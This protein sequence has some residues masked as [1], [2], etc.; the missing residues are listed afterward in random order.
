MPPKSPSA[1]DLNHLRG[2]TLNKGDAVAPPLVTAS[3][4][5][6]P[7]DPDGSASYGRSDNATWQTTE[8]LLSYLEQAPALLFPSG[9]AAI[10]APLFA[11]LRNGDRV[12]IPSDGY[13][14]TRLLADQFLARLGVEVD[15]RP[16]RSFAS[17][18]FDGYAMIFVETPSNPDLDLCDLSQIAEAAR[19]AGA[20]SVADNTTMTPF[21]QRPLDLGID[22]VVA[23]DTKAPSGH[24]D[25]LMGHVAS[26][27]EQIMERIEQWRRLS[28]SIPGPHE[29]WLLHR[30]LETLGLRFGQM[31]S[32]ADVIA[33]RLSQAMPGKVV[34]PGLADHPDRAL[35]TKQMARNGFLIGVTF[36]NKDVAEDFINNCS[37]LRP[38]TSFGGTHSSAERRA[39]WG[40]DVADGFVRISI[41]CEPAEELWGAFELALSQ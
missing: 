20:I 13:Y 14:A 8:H 18:G 25:I 29:A 15:Q 28:G 24:S 38:V 4:Y 7:G 2:R 34:Y 17:G 12:L 10:A 31:C 26:R 36:R 37:M 40:D 1:A 23:S 33:E 22:I 19:L 41:G 3:M 16:T 27:D 39:R 9:M 35:A 6:H 21:G 30:S 32:S 5:H 11:L